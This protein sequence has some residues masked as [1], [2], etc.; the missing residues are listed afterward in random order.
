VPG[1]EADLNRFITWYLSRLAVLFL[2]KIIIHENQVSGI[3]D[4]ESQ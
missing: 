1:Y 2:K 4:F 3:I